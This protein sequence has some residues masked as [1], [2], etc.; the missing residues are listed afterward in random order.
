MVAFDMSSPCSGAA[1][2][3]GWILRPLSARPYWGSVSASSR[4]GPHG[5]SRNVPLDAATFAAAD[6]PTLA[7]AGMLNMDAPEHTRLR[8][9][10]ARVFIPRRVALLREQIE[11]KARA[12]V[13]RLGSLVR[14][15]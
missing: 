3:I 10:V 4:R 8:S 12:L 13:A 9:I 11:T 15:P 6:V 7:S 1:R 2:G 5:H 14:W